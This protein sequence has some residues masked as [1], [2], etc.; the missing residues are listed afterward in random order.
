MATDSALPSSEL[1]RYITFAD[2]AKTTETPVDTIVTWHRL[3]RAMGFAFGEKIR[4]CWNFSPHE[5][6]QF[7]IAASLS[8]AGHPVGIETIRQILEATKDTARPDGSLFLKTKSTFAIIA[9]NLPGLWDVLAHMLQRAADA[10]E[11]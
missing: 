1:G 7:Q 2:V 10:I 3:I 4:G 8:T 11:D 9:V 6:Y 5:L